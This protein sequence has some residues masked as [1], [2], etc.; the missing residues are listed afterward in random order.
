MD[1]LTVSDL[2]R[3]V[4]DLTHRIERLETELATVR[5]LALKGIAAPQR[6][7]LNGTVTPSADQLSG[8]V[9][10]AIS[11]AVAAYLGKR[12]VIRQLRIAGDTAWAQQG[13]AAV[14]S[15][16]DFIHGFR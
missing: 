6:D 1:T 4:E 10:F 15:S 8:D 16:H 5:G 14:Q 13:R 12:A 2:H 3:Q 11:A 9:L 7:S